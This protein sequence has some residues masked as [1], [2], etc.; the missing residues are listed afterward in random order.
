MT[1]LYKRLEVYHFDMPECRIMDVYG[2]SARNSIGTYLQFFNPKITNVCWD[3]KYPGLDIEVETPK[4]PKERPYFTEQ[5][6]MT[7][8]KTYMDYANMSQEELIEW[9]NNTTDQRTNNEQT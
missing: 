8:L 6:Q 4:Y 9:F 5:D 7:L 2:K 3:E 1:H